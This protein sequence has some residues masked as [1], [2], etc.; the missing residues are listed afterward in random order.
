[1]CDFVDVTSHP[2][3]S[4]LDDLTTPNPASILWKQHDQLVLSCFFGFFFPAMVQE[5]I[6]GNDVIDL[7]HVLREMK[8]L[9]ITSVLGKKESVRLGQGKLIGG[10]CERVVLFSSSL[11]EYW[12]T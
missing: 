8:H 7:S 2:P 9:Y 10:P 11:S 3:P 12:K 1:M 4:F 5:T 6:V